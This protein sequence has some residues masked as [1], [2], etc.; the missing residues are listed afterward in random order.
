MNFQNPISEATKLDSIYRRASYQFITKNVRGVGF[1]KFWR[2][3]I[4]EKT[5][6]RLKNKYRTHGF[7]YFHSF[8][9][10]FIDQWDSVSC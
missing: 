10:S 1:L 9:Q 4:E 7:R 2:L 3:R 5:F 6:E 8:S